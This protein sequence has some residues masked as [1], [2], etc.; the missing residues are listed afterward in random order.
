VRRAHEHQRPTYHLF[1]ANI[2]G[3][4]PVLTAV[5]AS[6]WRSP[7]PMAASDRCPARQAHPARCLRGARA[8]ARRRH[9]VTPPPEPASPARRPGGPGNRKMCTCKPRR[10]RWND[11]GGSPALYSWH[12][13]YCALPRSHP[14]SPSPRSA[15]L[16]HRR[17]APAPPCTDHT[18]CAHCRRAV[19]DHCPLT[20]TRNRR[21]MPPSSRSPPCGPQSACELVGRPQREP[22]GGTV[23]ASPYAV[24]ET[25]WRRRPAPVVVHSR[26][27]PSM[28]R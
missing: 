3:G 17:H 26:C 15:A 24:R 2:A 1:P 11:Q 9:T 7:W 18:A 12:A 20:A 16:G 5:A 8:R 27:P 6:R 13:P 21:E 23:T 14:P 22:K 10:V 28:Q 19:R 25:W 4:A